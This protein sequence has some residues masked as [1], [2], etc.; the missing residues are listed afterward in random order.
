ML[1]ITQYLRALID[2]IERH[3]FALSDLSRKSGLSHATLDR[4][5]HQPVTLGA[6]G[7]NPTYRTIRE[8]EKFLGIDSHLNVIGRQTHVGDI[9][10]NLKIRV[11]LASGLWM[12]EQ[13]R[14]AHDYLE[15]LC[16]EN[17][18]LGLDIVDYDFIV[19]QCPDCA[20]HLL[21]S[22]DPQEMTSILRWGNAGD[23][24]GGRD[25]SG[26]TFADF[27]DSSLVACTQEDVPVF[28]S[29][30][31][32]LLTIHSRAGEWK[33]TGQWVDRRFLRYMAKISAP[34]EQVT[35]ISIRR[36][37][38]RNAGLAIIDTVVDDYRLSKSLREEIAPA[39]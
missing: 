29:T 27:S 31:I 2:A 22:E 6:G 39:N 30:D 15:F 9:S 14:R 7:F 33:Q 24:R 13:I 38:E 10:E 21:T 36:L 37:K 8:L 25:F 26:G 1:G 17:G 5:R 20:I 11:G 3:P 18:R 34:G 28:T 19:E 35:V 32:P 16:A 4:I 23:Y 12:D